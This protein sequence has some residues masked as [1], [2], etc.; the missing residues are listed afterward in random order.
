MSTL[1]KCDHAGKLPDC[2]GIENKT[3]PCPHATEHEPRIY[4]YLSDGETTCRTPDQCA[5]FK[6]R[7]VE[8]TK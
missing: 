4:A 5:G 2:A 7:C 3:Y 1:V 8:I 6:V